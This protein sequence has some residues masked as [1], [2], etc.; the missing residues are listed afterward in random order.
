[1]FPLVEGYSVK[2]TR[3]RLS[4]EIRTEV[5]KEIQEKALKEAKEKVT[6][7][8]REKALK[9]AQEKRLK[10]AEKLLRRGVLMEYIAEDMDLTPNEIEIL[11]DTMP[12]A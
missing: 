3:E 8:V 12:F 7:E 4:K 1:M 10:S 9:E 6:K 2:K 11:R 5:T